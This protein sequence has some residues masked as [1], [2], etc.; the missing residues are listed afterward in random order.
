MTSGEVYPEALRAQQLLARSGEAFNGGDYGAAVDLA[1]KAK[2]LL[3]LAEGHR[4]SGYAATVPAAE[5][6]FEVPIPLSVT[7]KSNLRAQPSRGA[8]V[9]VV[10]EPETPVMA[11]AYR[12]EWLRV[13]TAG[14]QSGWVSRTL[15]QAR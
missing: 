1:S 12:G 8:Q 10:L 3:D 2:Q 7:A 13:T 4:S 15:L 6:R 11:H 9:V 5:T 14:G